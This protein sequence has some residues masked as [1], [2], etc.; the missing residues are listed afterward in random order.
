MLEF[1]LVRAPLD[2]QTR[3]TV[4]REYNRL[5]GQNVTEEAFRRLTEE[6]PVGPAVHALLKAPDDRV[7]GHFCL[8]AYPLSWNGKE[9]IGATGE[10]LFVHEESRHEEIRGLPCAN[11]PPVLTLIRTLCRYANDELTWDP[12]LLAARP[13]VAALHRLAGASP[14]PLEAKECLLVLRPWRAYRLMRNVSRRQRAAMLVLGLIQA[15]LWKCISLLPWPTANRLRPLS[16]PEVCQPREDSPTVRFPLGS[17]FLNWRYSREHHRLFGLSTESGS[18]LAVKTPPRDFLRVLDTNLDLDRVAV[19]P[20]LCAL[21]R[22]ARRRKSLGVRWA[23]Y[24]NGGFPERFLKKLHRLGLVCARRTR[25][26]SI[27]TRC[28][29][30]ASAERWQFSDAA[31]A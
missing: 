7:V 28:G 24:R 15:P 8:Y 6:G 3:Q 27:Y 16:H 2:E 30:L 25:T 1:S 26:V 31:V 18:M 11:A 4:I 19:F 10:F 17:D 29:D 5:T 20:V 23:V 12:V 14:M 13:E 22:E 9:R 21:V